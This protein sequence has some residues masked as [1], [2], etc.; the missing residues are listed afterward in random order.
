MFKNERLLGSWAGVC[1]TVKRVLTVER[2]LPNSETGIKDGARNCSPTVN[3]KNREQAGLF[4]T[5]S[6]TGIKHGRRTTDQQ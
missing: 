5:N 3:G 6:E 2:G 1:P 4:S